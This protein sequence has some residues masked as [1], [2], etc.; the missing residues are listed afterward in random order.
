MVVVV[1]GIVVCKWCRMQRACVYHAVWPGER[2]PCLTDAPWDAG[3]WADAPACP[4]AALRDEHHCLANESPAGAAED[5]TH[6][7]RATSTDDDRAT[8]TDGDRATSTDDDRATF[9]DD[10]T[11]DGE[12]GSGTGGSADND[13]DGDAD[14]DHAARD[15]RP[16]ADDA[17]HAVR[18][19]CAPDRRQQQTLLL[20]KVSVRCRASAERVLL[21]IRSACTVDTSGCWQWP[22]VRR[23]IALRLYVGPT[24]RVP[25]V[26]AWECHRRARLRPGSTLR[27]TVGG[28]RCVNPAHAVLLSTRV[29]GIHHPCAK[30]TEEDVR[31]MRSAPPP[32]D[33]ASLA[34]RYGVT[35]CTVRKVLLRQTWQHVA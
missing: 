35:T 17:E 8:S 6:D 19:R 28:A 24:I 23:G 16:G 2:C 18:G 7:D 27:C 33:L 21:T 30:L 29:R 32:H 20:D 14:R 9:M 13:S 34:S 26:L 12:D 31:A 22:E 15:D 10:D 4:E 25:R 3:G 1:V 11:D 5:R